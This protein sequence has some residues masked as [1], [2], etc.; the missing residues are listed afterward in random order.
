MSFARLSGL[1]K[2]GGYYV[3]EDIHWQPDKKRLSKGKLAKG[4]TPVYDKN[5]LPATV[6]TELLIKQIVGDP[7][8]N[9]P[10]AINST[11]NKFKELRPEF[12]DDF[13]N[14]MRNFTWKDPNPSG[15]CPLPERLI[16]LQRNKE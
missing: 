9:N 13:I 16:V 15:K 8:K 11:F 2:P 12:A 10:D 5:Q 1:V 14:N 4:E 3:I 7:K 6:N